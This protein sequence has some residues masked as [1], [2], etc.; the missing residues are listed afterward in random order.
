MNHFDA[1]FNRVVL[2]EGG[3]SD[4]ARDSGGATR[5]GITERVARANGY[6]G[7]MRALPLATAR[8]IY[9]RQYW[10][11]MRLDQVAEVAPSIAEELFDTGVNMGAQRAGVFLQR[12]LNALNA[13]GSL[14][15]DMAVDG[16][17]GPVT[18]AALRAFIARRGRE[19]ERVLHRALNGLQAA[20]YVELA[21][22]REKDEAF[23]WGWLRTR[24]T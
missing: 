9:R 21:E 12:L 17:I 8:A 20:A 22:R 19:G 15:A 10:D 4:D 5:Y 3:Y 6:M 13:R 11:L 24:V 2:V 23:V 7:D 16:S 1:A 18:V 14:W